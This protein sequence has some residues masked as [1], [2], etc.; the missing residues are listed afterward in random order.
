LESTFQSRELL[1]TLMGLSEV[2]GFVVSVVTPILKV[3]LTL[4]TT[5]KPNLTNSVCSLT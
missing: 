5:L 1:R 2:F 4:I 3:Y